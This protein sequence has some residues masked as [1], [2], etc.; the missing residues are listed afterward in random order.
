MTTNYNPYTPWYA[1]AADY[2]IAIPPFTEVEQVMEWDPDTR[3]RKPKIDKHSGQPLWQVSCTLIHVPTKNKAF[4]GELKIQA[5][6][7]P[8]LKDDAKY[9]PEV[10]ALFPYVSGKNAQV[11]PRVIGQLHEYKENSSAAFSNAKAGESK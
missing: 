1:D 5:E 10:I 4:Q 3:E 6:S 2:V 9:T 8:D 7:K 11:A